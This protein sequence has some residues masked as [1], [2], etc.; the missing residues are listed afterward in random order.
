MENVVLTEG[1]RLHRLG[2]SLLPLHYKQKKPAVR[3]WKR[4]QTTRPD[5]ATIYHWWANHPERGLAIVL[6]QVSSCIVAR[7]FD[8][9]EA[10]EQWAAS[11]SEL[12]AKLPTVETS[13]G[14]HV[15]ARADFEAIRR[16]GK[17]T[18]YEF[19]DGE[20]RLSGCYVAAPPSMHPSGSQYR[21]LI[22]MVELP[23]V[24]DVF[25]CGFVPCNREDRDYRE[26]RANRVN[27]DDRADL[28]TEL[29]KKPKTLGTQV[30][31]LLKENNFAPEV[32]QQVLAAI[33]QTVPR[34]QGR[35]HEQ[36]FHFCR[37]LKAIQE[38]ADLDPNQLEEIVYLWW[39]QASKVSGTSWA[40]TLQDFLE[41]WPKVEFPANSQPMKQILERAMIAETP[42]GVE[43]LRGEKLPLMLL[44]L[45]RELQRRNPNKE[46]YLSCRIAGEL[47][48][49]NH[50]T[51]NRWLSLFERRGFL[52]VVER[53]SN[54]KGGQATRYR[55]VRPL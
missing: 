21:W 49:V 52:E 23:P 5:E 43:F 2:L 38:V 30:V 35:R 6:G 22:S 11:F 39:E 17:E 50:V 32:W 47:C 37:V 33:E 14:R 44:K 41:G 7:D 55:Y 19:D 46:F 51:A 31:A 53:G 1:L 48:G 29:P 54:R 3:S 27:P 4:Y 18:I 13:R 25:S 16:R 15:Y 24:V 42:A 45:C 36:V 12:A 28:A 10:Y 8:T 20:L 34:Q 40:E 26:N 9:M